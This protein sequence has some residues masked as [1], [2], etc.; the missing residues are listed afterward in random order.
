MNHDLPTGV[1]HVGTNI[2]RMFREWTQHLR[3]RDK[4]GDVV[5]F[6]LNDVQKAVSLV[7]ATAV[8]QAS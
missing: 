8:F 5:P 2:T 4:N 7:S 3:V 6:E 1:E